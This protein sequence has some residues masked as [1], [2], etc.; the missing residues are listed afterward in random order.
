MN[1]PQ[2]EP[3]RKYKWPW[4]F[5]GAAALFI[6]LAVLAVGFAAMKISSQR[7]FNT[8]LPGTAPMR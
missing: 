1:E 4:F 6:L 2:N 7:D 3:P 5:W 8:P